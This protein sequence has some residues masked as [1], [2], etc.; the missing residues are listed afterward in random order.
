M[1]AMID[2]RSFIVGAA[3]TVFVLL[4]LGASLGDSPQADRF[5]VETTAN[6]VFVLDT[7]TGQVWGNYISLRQDMKDE[8]FMSPKL[9]LD[10]K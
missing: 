2:L 4:A 10:K 9:S 7:A 1:K 8:E 5:Q 3:L 6:Y